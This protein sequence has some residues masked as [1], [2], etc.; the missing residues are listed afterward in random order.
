ME[1]KME[2]NM[3]IKAPEEMSSA[4]RIAFYDCEENRRYYQYGTNGG[5]KKY[6]GNPVFGGSY[7]TCF[8]VSLLL[9]EGR[10]GHEILRMWF[11]WRPKR[12]IGYTESRDGIS[13]SEPQLVLAPL[14]GSDWEEDEVNRP[15]VI[16][17]DGQYKMWYSGQ[18]LPYRE[19]GRS[20]IGLAVSGDGIHWERRKEPVLKPDQDWEKQAIMC[21]HVLFD[22]TEGSYKMWYAAGCNHE[23]DAIGYA[24]SIDGIHWDKYTDNPVLEGSRGHLWEQHKVVAPCV[25]KEAGWYYMFYVGHL[26]EERAQV[27]LARSRDGITGWEKHPQNPLIAPTQGDWDSV[28]VYKPFVM[29]VRGRWMMWYNGAAYDEPV[30]VFEQIGLAFLETEHLSW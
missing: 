10:D 9:E 6:E 13:W 5:W 27:G 26:H 1:V 17:H 29:K 15:A 16:Y 14:E 20:V 12:G 11:S 2:A 7:G 24:S 4:Q 8:D 18:M 25:V 19:G 23:P 21:P 30:W 3:K 28:A 22:E